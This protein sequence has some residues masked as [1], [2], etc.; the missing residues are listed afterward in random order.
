MEERILYFADPLCSWCYGF[1]PEITHLKS[2]YKDFDFQLVLGGLRPHGT[3]KI[4][5]IEDF[6]RHHWEEVEKKSG[7]LFRYEM[8]QNKDFVYDTEPPC[9]AVVT[10]RTLAPENEFDF[11]KDVQRAFYYHNK[12]TNKIEPYIELL[13]KYKIDNQLFT[14]K[15]RSET[16]KQLTEKDFMLTKEFGIHSFPTTLLQVKDK[17]HLLAKGYTEYRNLESQVENVLSQRVT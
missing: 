5:D 17:Y 11:F 1:S 14:K 16:L 9:R 3:E 4:T 12:D 2:K 6:L 8:L 13:G 7:Q 10:V 15:I